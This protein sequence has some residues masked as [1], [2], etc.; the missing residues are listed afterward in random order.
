MMCNCDGSVMALLLC[1]IGLYYCSSLEG[2][3]MIF[4]TAT[5][6]Q[7]REKNMKSSKNEDKDDCR[8][9]FFMLV[10]VFGAVIVVLLSVL[11][12]LLF[13]VLK[14]R[15]QLRE[16]SSSKLKQEKEEQ[17][18]EMMDYAALNFNKKN[19]RSHRRVEA[20]DPHVVYSSVRQ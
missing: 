6:L 7:I 1:G 19:K 12:F 18:G 17:D 14:Y 20:E 5:R 9:E 4:S 3:F 10:L 16:G 15:E 11:L 2:K 13:I 8:S